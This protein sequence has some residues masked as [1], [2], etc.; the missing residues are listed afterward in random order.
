MGYYGEVGYDVLSIFKK[1]AKEKLILFGRYEFYDTHNSTPNGT[2]KNDS[3]GRTDMTFGV[4]YKVSNGAAFKADYQIFDNNA[5]GNT[6]SNQ[7]NLG[8]GVW[9]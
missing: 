5:K 3:Y 6:P 4:T 8:V 9:F 2:T 7:I 1:D